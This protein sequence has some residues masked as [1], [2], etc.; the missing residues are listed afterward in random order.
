M[1]RVIL[2]LAVLLLAVPAL[3]L[4]S[5]TEPK[6]QINAV[7]QR[8]ATLILLKR[9]DFAAGWAKVPNTPDSNEHM[10][11]P[12]YN[13]NESDLTLTADAESSFRNADSLGSVFSTVNVYKTKAQALASWTRGVKPAAP[14][15]FAKVLKQ[16]FE[17]DGIRTTIVR[18]GWISFPKL[19]PRTGAMQI[20]LRLT[21]TSGGETRTVP[22]TITLVGVGNG[23]GDA[24]LMTMGFGNGIVMADVR[25][26]AKLLAQRLAAA[27]F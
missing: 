18:R 7:D 27:R 14:A 21:V 25:G 15:C 16:T 12:D 19:A 23:R 24:S 17:K 11:C 4:A 3:A 9:A 20:V 26:F 2:A 13:P 10:S 8:K 6:R 1:R 22:F 5:H